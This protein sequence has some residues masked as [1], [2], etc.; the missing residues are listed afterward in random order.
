M[1]YAAT[2]F[3]SSYTDVGKCKVIE[4]IDEDGH[5]YGDGHKECNGPEGYYLEE[6][7]SAN[8]DA[9]SVKNRMDSAWEMSLSPEHGF[10]V[11]HFGATT[12]WRLD[13]KSAFAL[14][15]RV[16]TFDP[17]NLKRIKEFLLIRGLKG[18]EAIHADID[19]RANHDANAVARQ[20]VDSLFLT[21]SK[22]CP[23]STS[24]MIETP[25]KR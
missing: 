24:Q 25:V 8:S 10:S 7:Y 13:G 22:G 5:S 18:C 6:S 11:Q 12:E 14:I 17:D 16:S 1:V 23:A 2:S 9:R 3:S 21:L 4:D 15:Q 19:A 20:I